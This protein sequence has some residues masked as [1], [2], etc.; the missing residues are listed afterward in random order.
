MT[1]S[2]AQVRLPI[3]ND[4]VELWKR[5]ESQLAPMLEVLRRDPVHRDLQP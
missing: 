5:Y 2:A 3:Y 1:A 4:S